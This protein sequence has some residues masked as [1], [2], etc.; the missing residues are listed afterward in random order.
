MKVRFLTALLFCHLISLAAESKRGLPAITVA[1]GFTVELAAG[2]ELAPYGMLADFDDRGRLFIAAS[3]GK[4]IGGKAMSE[5][6]E[7]KI[8]MLEDR[9]GDGRFDK[10]TVYAEHVGIPMGLLC[11][12]G[13]VYTASPPDVLRLRDAD[14][15]GKADEREVLA[16]GWHVRGTASLHGPFLGPEGKLYLTDGRHGFDI[17]TKDGRS[18]KGL[19]SRIWRMNPDGTE[20]E[21]VAGGGFDN[22]VEII[23]TPGGEI[24]G[25]MT[26][27]TNPKNGQRDS[28]MHFLEGGVYSKWHSSVTE[29]KRTGDLLGPLT[30]FAR[31]APAGLHRHSGLSFGGEFQGNL[32]SAQFNPHRIQR[33]VLKRSGATFTSADSDFLV[34]SDPDFRPTDVLEAPDGS[35]IVIDTG[36]W[37][38]DQCPL[39]RISRPEHKGGVYRVRKRGAQPIKDS[40]GKALKL[41]RFSPEELAALL[42]DNRPQLREKATERLV[43]LG[44]DSVSGLSALIADPKIAVEAKC[45]AVW[46]LHRQRSEPARKVIRGALKHPTPEVQIAAARSTGLAKDK[47]ALGF[48]LTGL[49]SKDTAVS[50]EM[51]T[52]LGFMGDA[53]ATGFLTDA[54]T[55]SSDPHHDHAIIYSLILLNEPSVL[56]RKLKAKHSRAQRAALIALDQLDENPLAQSD[57]APLL[58]ATD[59]ELSRAAL[60]VMTHHPDWAASV[61]SYLNDQVMA[62]SQWSDAQKETVREAL[63]VFANNQKV[64]KAMTAW[65]GGSSSR[66]TENLE[67]RRPFLF[68][69]MAQV[70][71]KKFPKE[72]ESVLTKALANPKFTESTKLAAIRVIQSRGLSGVDTAL[73][74]LANDAKESAALRLAA[75]SAGASRVKTVSRESE[76]FLHAQHAPTQPATR[77]SAAAR[78]TGQLVWN[79]DQRVGIAKKWL[80]EADGLTWPLLLPAFAN[81]SDEAVGLALVKAMAEAPEGVLN[82]APVI[83]I[84]EGYSTRVKENAKSL[85]ARLAKAKKEELQRLEALA[86]L[87]KGGDVGRG[88]AVFFGQKAVCGACHTIGAKGGNLGPDLTSVGAIRSG[89]DI[90]EAIVFPNAT[91]VPG[92]EAFVVKAKETYVGIVAHETSRALTLRSAPGVEVRLERNLI[93]S[94]NL[95]PVSLMPAGLDRNVSEAEFRDLLAFLQSQNGERWLQPASL[96]NKDLRVRESGIRN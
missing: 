66:P 20:L 96:G 16:S 17:K 46:V 42:S 61:V 75:L 83:K 34:S 69:V 37:Y 57:V 27:F 55:A 45:R 10:S 52:A 18:F 60:W 62:S 7:C 86:P 58:N 26:Y 80:G 85:L 1:E 3:S 28:L 41:D 81:S 44:K 5:K 68:S 89:R 94:I 77:R 65:L 23:F 12:Q 88:R 64:Q 54:A 82:E 39:S 67:V 21:S 4:N 33:H 30:R 22:P 13:N 11:W 78:V 56:K 59:P 47:T 15:D 93:Q 91:Q 2:P 14:D 9:N 72:W 70:E 63:T 90:L 6:P 38:I 40:L 50:R 71:V 73:Q 24:I 19:A 87:L 74:G 25:T 84:L 36:G 49:L 92:H 79:D 31:V 76:R 48:V 8:L 43:R 95:S 29:F 51:A 53:A 35:L 32:F